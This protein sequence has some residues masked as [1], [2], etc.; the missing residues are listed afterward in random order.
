MT[1]IEELVDG[2]CD[3]ADWIECP[4]DYVDFH[5][6]AIVEINEWEIV[7]VVQKVN[8]RC[9][10]NTEHAEL[11]EPW[12]LEFEDA[13]KE[14]I[15]L[16][17]NKRECAEVVHFFSSGKVACMEDCGPDPG[18]DA[19]ETEGVPQVFERGPVG[20]LWA[21]LVQHVEISEQ[22]EDGGDCRGWLL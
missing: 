9:G 7:D 6:V 2:P 3:P 4:D 5:V 17:E 11:A 16:E 18:V 14:G 21:H 19:D 22:I 10:Y 8:N 20:E 13:N 1:E 15:K 12:A